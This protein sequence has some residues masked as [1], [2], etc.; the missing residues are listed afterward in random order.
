MKKQIIFILLLITSLSYAQV[1]TLSVGAIEVDEAV[2]ITVDI[3][4]DTD[5]NC[6][7]LINPQK[8]YMH[9]G[10]GDNSNAFGFSVIGNWGEDDG[11]SL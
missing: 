6:N 11:R 3:N 10:I 8:V 2:T 9:S 5:T 7:G 1:V 4:N